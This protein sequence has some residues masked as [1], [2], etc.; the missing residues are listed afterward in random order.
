MHH[1][2]ETL[3]V[4]DRERVLLPLDQKDPHEPRELAGNR[5]AV[6]AD[7]ACDFGMGRGW[8]DACALAMLASKTRQRSS[9]A[10][11]RLLTASVEN[12]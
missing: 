2:G 4:L 10:W 5:L 7:P 8:G 12:S 1:L 3:E 9:S 6:G 11:M